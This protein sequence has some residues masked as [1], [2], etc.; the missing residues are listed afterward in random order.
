LWLGTQGPE[1]WGVLKGKKSQ[2]K[3]T[4]DSLPCQATTRMGVF[5][6]GES[7]RATK[8]FVL[9]E[10]EKKREKEREGIVNNPLKSDPVDDGKK[11][12]A[13][14]RIERRGSRRLKKNKR[15]QEKRGRGPRRQE[16]GEQGGKL[17]GQDRTKDF[18]QRFGIGETAIGFREK[19]GSRESP[20]IRHVRRQ[21]SN[22][23]SRSSIGGRE[24]SSGENWAKRRKG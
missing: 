2:Q 6:E 16:T 15:K 4:S 20:E 12:E 7:R 17:E 24:K 5:G 8:S 11:N 10:G 22:G 21:I 23:P 19:K 13:K 14:T 3:K 18:D 9:Q 1:S